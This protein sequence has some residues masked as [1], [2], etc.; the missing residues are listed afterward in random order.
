MN[1][2]VRIIGVLSVDSNEGRETATKVAVKSGLDLTVYRTKERAKAAQKKAG[3][4]ILEVDAKG[5][6]EL[7]S[8]FGKEILI[9]RGH[10]IPE[11]ADIS[12]TV[13]ICVAA[14]D[15]EPQSGDMEFSSDEEGWLDR[16]AELTNFSLHQ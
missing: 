6:G 7:N 12:T 4:I 16:F 5:L 13:V 10:E 3:G 14:E 8:E 2:W 9:V 15:V 1:V 11:A